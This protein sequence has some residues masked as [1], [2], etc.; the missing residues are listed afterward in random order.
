[1][2]EESLKKLIE[3]ARER[4]TDDEPLT[5]TTALAYV[6][7]LLLVVAHEVVPVVGQGLLPST[8]ARLIRIAQRDFDE[9]GD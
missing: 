7:E 6:A 3:Y 1:M 8:E 9:G 4:D 5:P 2:D